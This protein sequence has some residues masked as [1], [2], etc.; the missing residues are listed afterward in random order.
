MDPT[1]GPLLPESIINLLNDSPI[2]LS[3]PTSTSTPQLLMGNSDIDFHPAT[4]E[5]HTKGLGQD[6]LPS[7]SDG[8]ST[9]R[10][11]SPPSISSYQEPIPSKWDSNDNNKS[12]TRTSPAEMSNTSTSL[13]SLQQYHHASSSSPSPE[14]VKMTV[15]ATQ[16]H[17]QSPTGLNTQQVI[18]ENTLNTPPP[19]APESPSSSTPTDH[20]PPT[21]LPNNKPV[22]Y[23]IQSISGS[24]LMTLLRLSRKFYPAVERRLGSSY[25][26]KYCFVNIPSWTSDSTSQKQTPS[27]S[28]WQLF[29]EQKDCIELLLV[30]VLL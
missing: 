28:P 18:P 4:T 17:P 5:L 22:K 24:G 21:P 29:C 15:E 7:T 1:I 11:R 2:T 10:A 13:L 14:M 19:L 16:G 30:F 8:P 12:P 26:S 25:S 6:I 3:V 9:L 27:D 23:R 20:S